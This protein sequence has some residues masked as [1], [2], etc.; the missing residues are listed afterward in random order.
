VTRNEVVAGLGLIAL[1]LVGAAVVAWQVVGSLR[2]AGVLAPR[3][4]ASGDGVTASPEME[5]ALIA[6][7]QALAEDL[8]AQREPAARATEASATPGWRAPS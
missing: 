1:A 4:P 6:L 2:R 3:P 7:A 5:R 8:D